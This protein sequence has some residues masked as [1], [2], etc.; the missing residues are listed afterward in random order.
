[1]NATTHHIAKAL[2]SATQAA[3]VSVA[4]K[5]ARNHQ[6]PRVY[7]GGARAGYAGGPQVKV[8][9]L[10][11]RFTPVQFGFNLAYLLSGALYLPAASLRRLKALDIPI[12][13]NQN[14]VFFPAWYPVG[15]EAQNERMARA[16]ESASHVFYQSVFCKRAADRFLG[17]TPASWEILYN[18]VD[19][20][21]FTPAPREP[22]AGRPL[23]LLLTGK[24]GKSTMSRLLS[25]IEG[26]AA[27]RKGGIDAVLDVYGFV[28]PEVM[29]EASIMIDRLG[30]HGEVIFCG[31][32]TRENAAAIYRSADVYVMNKHNDACPNAVLEAM[33][34]GLPVLYSA[35]GGVPELVGEEA[36]VGLPIEES[37]L[38]EIT[39]TAQQ[40]AQGLSRL[41]Q[42]YDVYALQARNRVCAKFDLTHWFDRH[43][44]IFL[45]L[46]A[47]ERKVGI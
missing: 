20:N 19:T 31:S 43:E 4:R 3:V 42:N 28:A 23:K 7:Y 8:G 32:Y 15:W 47:H 13:L 2:W 27:A 40:F 14:G 18:G 1:M 9:L 17:T 22:L 11:S 44:Q 34:C 45:D 33:A 6:G 21:M 36:G 35:S 24:I 46:L 37:F 12:V 29:V 41:V 26:L 39:P 5:P 16:V 38:H 10:N 30:L 25:T